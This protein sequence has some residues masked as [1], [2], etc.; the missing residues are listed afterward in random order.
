MSHFA[1]EV[2]RAQALISLRTIWAPS[3]SA[4]SF[5]FATTA[6]SGFMPQSEVS[7]TAR[8]GRA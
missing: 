3:A 5:I 7:V 2:V 1:N 4:F 8:L 6:R